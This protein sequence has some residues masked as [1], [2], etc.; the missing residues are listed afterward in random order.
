MALELLYGL[1]VLTIGFL[2][3]VWYQMGN[4]SKENNEQIERLIKKLDREID[5]GLEK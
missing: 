1:S 2:L 5:K 3:G 4:M